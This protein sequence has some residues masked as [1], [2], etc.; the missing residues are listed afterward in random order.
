MEGLECKKREQHVV[1]DTM[2]AAVAR[3]STELR[4]LWVNRLFEE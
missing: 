2:S 4:Y 3:R 1:T